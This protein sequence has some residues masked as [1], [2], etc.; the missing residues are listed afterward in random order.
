[1]KYI[2]L[3]RNLAIVCLLLSVNYS[4]SAKIWRV[5]NNAGV[6]A[7]F[8]SLPAAVASPLV[9]SGD[10][11]HI[12]SSASIYA[13]G[14]N[15]FLN[16]RLIILGTGYFLTQNPKTQANPN[17][18]TLHGAS[19]PRGYIFL[20]AAASG[21]VLMGLDI[22]ELRIAAASNL[23]IARNNIKAI[24]LNANAA[25]GVSDNIL[26]YGNYIYRGDNTIDQSGINFYFGQQDVTYTNFR[27][28]N[29]IIIERV[30]IP[31]IT[32]GQILNNYI[33]PFFSATNCLIKNNYMTYGGA[34]GSNIFQY[35][36]FS[37]N[38]AAI[39]GFNGNLVAASSSVF[40][41]T[42]IGQDA[43]FKLSGG[44][45]AIGAGRDA[46]N[47]P[48]DIGPFGGPSPYVLSGMPPIPSIY[49]LSVPQNVP[50]GTSSMSVTLSTISRN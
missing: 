1:M 35:N 46:A 44:S 10:T 39:T 50:S 43:G 12:E 5:N 8:T 2:F 26:I 37:N 38:N 32:S 22:G 30:E 47:N 40:I 16:K 13:G 24:R 33:G 25:P 28:E 41:G 9:M 17:P 20:D 45:P 4:A 3:H 14:V 7:N 23:V 11:L 42:S 15:I 21:T 31:F 49:A 48:I 34:V 29:N 18:S 36:I 6:N 27:V 19:S